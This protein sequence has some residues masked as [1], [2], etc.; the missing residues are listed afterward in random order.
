MNHT[1]SKEFC[2]PCDSAY[3]SYACMVSPPTTPTD[4]ELDRQIEEL[5]IHVA[6]SKAHKFFIETGYH[7]KDSV[8]VEYQRKA[9]AQLKQLIQKARVETADYFYW[10]ID[11]NTLISE[12]EGWRG[13]IDNAKDQTLRHFDVAHQAQADKE[14]QG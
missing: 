10:R 14:E 9:K 8:K 7:L 12:L 11:C 6:N 3:R 13:C 5:A 2:E 4:T 1:Y